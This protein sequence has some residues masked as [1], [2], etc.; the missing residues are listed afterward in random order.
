[1]KSPATGLMRIIY[2]TRFSMFGLRSAWKHE[3][4]FRQEIALVVPLVIL[5]FWLPVEKIEQILLIGS[6]MLVVITELLNSAVEV[7]VDRVGDE[8]NELSGR[9]KDIAS[10]AVFV[11][12]AFALFTWVWILI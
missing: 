9:A 1:M 6:L 10:A 2:A 4:A 8:W 7:V 3:A 11:S 12:L 5:T